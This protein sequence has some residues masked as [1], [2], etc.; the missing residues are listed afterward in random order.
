[1][2]TLKQEEK[3]IDRLKGLTEIEWTSLMQE[4]RDH[5][6]KNDLGHIFNP[7]SD[8]EDLR[9][10][11]DD[12]NEKVE[13]LESKNSRLEDKLDEINSLSER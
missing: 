10:E 5:L 6:I 3:L 1:M 2:I 13:K 8:I 12:L 11:I 7:V 9:G 4:L